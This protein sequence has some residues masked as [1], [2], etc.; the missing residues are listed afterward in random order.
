MPGT[1]VPVIRQ[2]FGPGDRLP[3]WAGG[4]PPTASYLFDTG[5]DP[6]ERENRAGSRDEEAMAD[7]LSVELRRISAPPELRERVGL[8]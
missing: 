5:I 6:E 2:P 4:R 1:G 7:A 8:G 3:F